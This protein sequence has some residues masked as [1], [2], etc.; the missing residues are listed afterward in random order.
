M[1]LEGG[2]SRAAVSRNIS[3]LRHEG[4]PQKQSIAIALDVAR[5]GKKRVKTARE[6]A[7][8]AK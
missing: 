2:S 5:R 4:K 3:R 1:P 7:S 6:K 8:R